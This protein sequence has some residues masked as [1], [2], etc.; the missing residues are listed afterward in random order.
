MQ[1]QE[2]MQAAQGFYQL[3]AAGG[4]IPL[5]AAS[6]LHTVASNAA[7]DYYVVNTASADQQQQT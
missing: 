1:E 2:Y 6:S 3:P 7:P 4:P 5:D